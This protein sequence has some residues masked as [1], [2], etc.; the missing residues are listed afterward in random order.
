M[1]KISQMETQQEHLFSVE[2][3]KVKASARYFVLSVDG[4]IAYFTFPY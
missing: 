4:E 3:G 2:L 1:M